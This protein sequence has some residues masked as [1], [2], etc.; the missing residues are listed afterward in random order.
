[1]ARSRFGGNYQVL[2]NGGCKKSGRLAVQERY[3]APGHQDLRSS[4][5][6]LPFPKSLHGP[7]RL[8]ECQPFHSYIS[9][10]KK[11]KGEVRCPCWDLRSDHTFCTH[12]HVSHWLDVS[13]TAKVSFKKVGKLNFIAGGQSTM[14]K[15]MDS[16][17]KES[18]KP[19]CG[20]I[21]SPL[22]HQVKIKR[23][24]SLG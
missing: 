18:G 13:P 20:D 11:W 24:D 23:A 2:N 17:N 22:P 7:R 9:D 5:M 1:M 21:S 15:Y 3:G 16:L 8:L 4:Y 6:R 19:G 12:L 14:L 10:S